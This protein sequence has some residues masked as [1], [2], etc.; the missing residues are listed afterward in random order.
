M[1]YSS[2]ENC[3]SWPGVQYEILYVMRMGWV[4]DTGQAEKV[5]LVLL[6]T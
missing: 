4:V 1:I 3:T 5:G 6:C 2:K